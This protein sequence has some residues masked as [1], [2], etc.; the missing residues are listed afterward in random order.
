MFNSLKPDDV[1][2]RPQGETVARKS[3]F[4]LPSRLP[5]FLLRLPPQAG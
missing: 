2:L 4:A 5:T 1:V 3:S